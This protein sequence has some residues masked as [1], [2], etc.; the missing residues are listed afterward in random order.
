MN[1]QATVSAKQLCILLFLSLCVD[2]AVRSFTSGGMPPAQRAIPAA[3]LNAAATSLL[4]IFPL[5]LQRGGTG[6]AW[7]GDALGTKL[8]SF[9]SAL[10]LAAAGAAAAIRAEEFFRYG[11]DEPMPHLLVYTVF[12][13]AAFYALRCGMESLV[14]AVGI[15]TGIF[16]ASML[17]MLLSNIGGMRLFNLAA[18][19]FEVRGILQTAVHG[20]VLPPEL[21]LFFLL[22]PYVDAAEKTP[23]YRTIAMLCLFYIA[24]SFCAQAVLG[25]WAEA[26]TQTVHTL[27]RLGSLSV[28]RRLDALHTAAWML[29]E[30]C[31]LSALACGVQ[32]AVLRILP[33]RLQKYADRYAVGMLALLIPVC[34]GLGQEALYCA[35]TIAT[36]ALLAVMTIYGHIR[37]GSY[38]KKNG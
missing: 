22:R 23:V 17:L 15:A 14:R 38:A 20:F 24:L 35:F 9:F 36:A 30:L 13:S 34:I 31:K 26:Q 10:V 12:L 5:R 29:A 32:S 11:C 21:L 28:F 27:S 3:I 7:R 2:M 19:P 6:E 18:E 37:E 1:E 16:L 4:L 33:K 8:L 25:A